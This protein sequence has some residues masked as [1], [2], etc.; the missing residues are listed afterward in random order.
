ML[1]DAWVVTS[2][3]F[4]FLLV[5]LVLRYRRIRAD[6]VGDTAR[7][8]APAPQ[9]HGWTMTTVAEKA[10]ARSGKE[11]FR[12]RGRRWGAG[13]NRCLPGGPR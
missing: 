12:R 5:M 2:G 1:R 13:W 10:V 3:C 8:R 7:A 11:R 4:V 6:E 9:E